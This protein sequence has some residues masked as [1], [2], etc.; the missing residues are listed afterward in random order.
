[1]DSVPEIKID[2]N[3]F[4]ICVIDMLLLYFCSIIKFIYVLVISYKLRGDH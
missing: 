1:M 2:L 4:L 3:W